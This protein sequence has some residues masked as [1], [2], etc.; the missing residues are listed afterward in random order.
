MCLPNSPAHMRQLIGQAI[1]AL[2]GGQK[3]CYDDS[4]GAS[5]GV[6]SLSHSTHRRTAS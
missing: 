5:P 4:S 6:D 2:G 3:R 1:S